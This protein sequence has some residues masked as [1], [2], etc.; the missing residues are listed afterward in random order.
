VA[1][2]V[3]DFDGDTGASIQ[4]S[5]AL[6]GIGGRVFATPPVE[7]GFALVRVP[8]LAG[9]PILR[10]NQVVGH[11]DAN[12][13]LLVRQL[14]PYYANK[15]ALDQVAVPVGHALHTPERSVR[16]ARNTGSLITL[17]APS[18]RAATGHFRYANA[19][20]GD[21]ARIG[22]VAM[23]LGSD[24]L[25]Y[26]EQLDAGPHVATIAHE[27]GAWQCR[28]ELPEGG[29]DVTDVGEIACEDGP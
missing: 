18:V 19:H 6:V 17:E 25:F 7:N 26:F 11:T 23:P 1:A 15:V 24:G 4:A 5:G 2:N 3:Q 9:V 27:G 22:D 10:E 13:D 20:A 14:L 16:V 8:G 29:G 21:E 28:F 12:G